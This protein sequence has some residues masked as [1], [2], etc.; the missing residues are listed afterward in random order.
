MS[1]ERWTHTDND[2]DVGTL[3]SPDGNVLRLGATQSGVD[4]DRDAAERLIT[5]L[6]EHFRIPQVV[7][8]GEPQPG[9]LTPCVRWPGHDGQH[10]GR[11][12]RS[13]THPSWVMWGGGGP[14]TIPCPVKTRVSEI[15]CSL[16]LDHEGPHVWRCGEPTTLGRCERVMGHTG[17]HGDDGTDPQPEPES[18]VSVQDRIQREHTVDRAHY[19]SQFNALGDLLRD[20]F[21][22]RSSLHTGMLRQH[23]ATYEMLAEQLGKIG[24]RTRARATSHE[25]D[26]ITRLLTEIRDRLPE[27]PPQK[28][29]FAH[30]PF[31][32]DRNRC[33]RSAGHTGN[34]DSAAQA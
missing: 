11:G 5:A 30:D 28:C 2:G 1:D 29:G 27:P 12:D 18:E 23:A 32:D 17:L 14:K 25:L 10:A 34:H 26:G 31:S 20:A 4:L 7:I 9:T 15:P 16:L 13:N 19:T 3:V 21:R 24:D 22:Q 33:Q 8:C 6:A